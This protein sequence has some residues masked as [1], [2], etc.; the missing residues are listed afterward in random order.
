MSLGYS[1]GDFIVG[2]N[3]TYRL[4][5]ALSETKGACMEYQEAMSELGALQQTFLQVG[6]LRP[7]HCLSQATINAAAYIVLSS[8]ELIGEFLRKTQ[9]YRQRFTRA[10]PGHAVSDSWQKMG[11]V[12]FKR[13]ELKALKDNLHLRLT[14]IGVLLSTAEM[15]EL[16]YLLK[17]RS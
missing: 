15:Y 6:Y 4:I 8:V 16:K 11:W 1:L 13:E 17:S 7:S 2:A 9:K 14:N 12:L 3:M 10:G 5:R